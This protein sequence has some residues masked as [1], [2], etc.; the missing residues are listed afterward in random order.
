MSAPSEHGPAEHGL[1]D[2]EVETVEARP[3]RAYAPRID[4]A[5]DRGLITD[6]LDRPAYRDARHDV[7]VREVISLLQS[8]GMRVFIVGGAPRD[9]LDGR[10]GKDIDLCVDAGVDDALRVLA[11]AYPDIDAVRM[12]NARFGVAR[13]GDH[14]SGGIDINMLRSWK[15]IRNDDMWSTTFVPRQD[16]LED[17]QMR[18]FSVNALYFDCREQCLLDPLG[19]DLD[20]L[21]SRRLRLITHPRVLETSY[22]TTFRIAQFIARGYRATERV[23]AHLAGRADRDIQG[24]GERIHRWIPQHL[25]I[26]DAHGEEFRRLLYAHA[27]EPAS[28]EALDR[29][30]RG[31]ARMQAS[32]ASSMAPSSMAPSSMAPFRRVFSAGRHEDQGQRLGGTEVLHL[33]AHRGRLYASLSYKLHDYRHDDPQHGAQIAVLDRADGPWRL[34]YSAERVHW[35]TTLESVTFTRDAQGRPLDAPVSRLLAGPSDSRG[36]VH[37][38]SFDDDNGTWTRTQLGVG[39]GVAST[40]SFFIHRDRVTGHERVFAGTAPTGIFSGVHDPGVP[41]GIRWDSAPELSGYTRRPMSFTECNGQL[42]VSIKPDIYRRIDGPSPRW[43]RVYTIPVPLIVPSSGFRGLTTVP[44]PDGPG[45]VLLAALEGDRCRIVRIDPGDH[46]RETL[47]LDVLD[48]LA[49][50]WGERPTYAVAAYDDFTPVDDP[51]G[52]ERRLLCGLG[53]T[54]S[55]QLDTHPADAWVRDAWYLIRHPHG[56]HYTLGRVDESDETSAPE[57]VAARTFA[58]SPFEPGMLYVGGY[59]PNAKRCR[60][61]A[62]VCAVSVAT[63][64]RPALHTPD[65]G[66]SG[67]GP[68]AETARE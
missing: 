45:E 64:I 25:H 5:L 18:D 60:N 41:G 39:S 8:A 26:D 55:T 2:P 56:R 36:L 58:A 1:D 21:Y 7:R 50:H 27:R 49:A 59:D 12:H 63:A 40:R 52:G 15:D 30:F 31:T 53:A 20:D 24:M 37:V 17:A 66:R 44:N 51:Q 6:A 33:V 4:I 43:E 65:D 54:Y 68:P 3:G 48:F 29:Y 47:E 10:P 67:H 9:W 62:W 19:C 13:W 32:T 34:V 11:H 61:T 14:A 46:F 57:L 22:R 38:D 16:L 42:Y 28:I 23:L 35:R